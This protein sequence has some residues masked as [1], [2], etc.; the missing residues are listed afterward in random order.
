M[1]YI[2][3]W[4][5]SLTDYHGGFCF[6]QELTLKSQAPACLTWWGILIWVVSWYWRSLVDDT[7]IGLPPWRYQNNCCWSSLCQKWGR[8]IYVLEKLTEIL[9]FNEIDLGY[10]YFPELCLTQWRFLLQ[11][12]RVQNL[13]PCSGWGMRDKGLLCSLRE[14]K[15]G[16]KRGEMFT[17]LHNNNIHI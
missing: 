4:L 9:L 10:V 3:N 6:K 1:L 7:T 15:G 14:K 13:S 8:E 12:P 5:D 17:I 2:Y 11:D 16:R